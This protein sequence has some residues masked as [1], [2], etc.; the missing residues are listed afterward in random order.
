MLTIA[1]RHGTDG[2]GFAAGQRDIQ[3]T[4]EKENQ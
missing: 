1:N 2:A 4:E 3:K